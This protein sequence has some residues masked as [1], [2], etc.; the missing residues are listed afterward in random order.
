MREILLLVSATDSNGSQLQQVGGEKLPSW[1]GVGKESEG[2][3]AGLPGTIFS[4][5]LTDDKG[6]LNVPFWQATAVAKDTRIRPKTTKTLK[7]HFKLKNP[8]DE[9]S[10]SASLIYRPFPR[11][12]IKT[13]KWD[14]KDTK[15]ASS[16]W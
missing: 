14:S 16:A 1:A 12:L 9:P 7:F 13:K 11:D 15:I 5:V 6:N 2:N 10:A 4:K 8:Q 3:Y